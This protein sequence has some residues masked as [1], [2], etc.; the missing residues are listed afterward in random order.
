MIILI[1]GATHTGKTRLAQQLLEKYK[2][3]YLSID[4]L[5][6]GL[7]RSGNT[8]LTP[9]DDN[10]LQKILW[11]I[12]REIIN[13]A[14]ENNQN[15]IVEGGYIPFDWSNDFSSQY[16]SEISYLCLVMSKEYIDL[17]YTDIQ[18]YESVIEKRLPDTMPSKEELV[19]ENNKY[20][21]QCRKYGLDY[22]V[23]DKTYP[24]NITGKLS[25]AG[26]KRVSSAS[27]I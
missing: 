8:S 11:P 17:H 20:L 7:I 21:E 19:H 16:L 1:M 15:L 4:H 27:P 12:V 14:I 23:I 9:E 26:S 10:E 3:P 22:T 25:R 18:R 24:E 5:K 6:M 2:F 13:T